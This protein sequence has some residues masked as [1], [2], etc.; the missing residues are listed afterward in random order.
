[1]TQKNLDERIGQQRD[2][3]QKAS[4]Y[5]RPGGALCYVTCS[6]LPEENQ[7]QVAAFLEA[8]GS[9]ETVSALDGWNTLFGEQQIKPHSA[10]GMTLTLSP[11]LT[12]TDGFY[13]A[14]LRKKA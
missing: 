5:V 10:D 12:D 3:L 11:A 1:L 6:V 7:A 13:F 4:A 9:F 2:A 8:D 14:M